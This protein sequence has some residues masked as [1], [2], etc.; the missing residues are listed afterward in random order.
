MLETKSSFT[1][2]TLTKNT[3]SEYILLPSLLDH[4]VTKTKNIFFIEYGRTK[5]TSSEENH[6]TNTINYKLQSSNRSS[7]LP[8]FN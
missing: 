6:P 7:V 5:N 8:I 1:M 2:P 4:I 3:I